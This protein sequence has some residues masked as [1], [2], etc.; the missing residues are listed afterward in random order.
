MVAIL[1]LAAGLSDLEFRPESPQPRRSEISK[2]FK[3][4][5]PELRESELLGIIL[6]VLAI[7]TVLFLPMAIYHLTRSPLLRKQFFRDLVLILWVVA[8]WLVLR[9][10]PDVVDEGEMQT[11]NGPLAE[12][13]ILPTVEAAAEYTASSSSW[14]VLLTTIGLA[15]L[16]AAGLLGMAWF[17][18]HRRRPAASPLEDLAQ[19]AQEALAALGAGADVRDTV[20]RCY[21]EMSRVL[22][23]RRGIRRAEAMTP[24]EFER[25]LKEVGLPEPPIEQLTRLFERVRYGARIADKGD[26]RQAI[27]CLTAVVEACKRSP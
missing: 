15:A 3:F 5:L 23:E 10:S 14:A 4:P 6:V 1:L 13:N 21:F 24:R 20:L 27:D 22:K 18:W 8:L 17:F 16:G 26:E 11:Y 9:A 25:Q 2:P 19:E 7:M 12:A